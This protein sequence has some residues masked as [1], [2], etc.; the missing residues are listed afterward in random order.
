MNLAL[1]AAISLCLAGAAAA[2]SGTVWAW[3]DNTS[4]E[5]G[6]NSTTSS[7]SAVQ[8]VGPSG[9][10]HLT[11][12]RAVA[13]GGDFTVA[14]RS[15][16][17]V[18]AWGD[19]SSGELGD[20][21]AEGQSNTPVQVLGLNG[22]GF[23]TGVRAVAAGNDFTV[24][25]LSDGTIAAW[26]DNRSGQLGD[27][28]TSMDSA[29]AVQ[30]AGPGGS[31]VLS[32]LVAVAAGS[33]HT[34][35]LR[36]DGTVWAWGD[37]EYG[38]LGN[39]TTTGYG[40]N[41]CPVQVLGLNGSGYLT[42]VVAVA[43][44]DEFTVA[45]KSDGTVWAWGYNKFG[46]V[47]DG[48]TTNR[49]TPV[50]VVG[51]RGTGHLT[52]VV[53]VAAGEEPA[54]AVKSDGTVWCWGSGGEGEL[55]D[56]GA[57]PWTFTP[58]QVLGFGGSGYLTGVVA[59][60][61]GW[62]HLVALKSDGT[63]AAW[64]Y[65]SSGELGDNGPEGQSNVPVPVAGLGGAGLLTGIAAV[66]AGDEFTVALAS[67]MLLV[68][69]S[70][71]S[72]W[73]YQ[74]TPQSTRDRHYLTLTTSVT[75][76]TWGGNTSYT[77]T[78]SLSGSGLVRPSATFVNSSGGGAV[79]PTTSFAFA[80][81]T[82]GTLYLVGGRVQGGGV[83]G[84][85]ANLAVTGNCTVTVSVAGNSS[86]ASHPATA[87]VIINVSVLGDI[88]DSG[89]VDGA[90]LAT[91][92]SILNKVLNNTGISPQTNADGDLSGDSE[93]TAADRVILYRIINGLMVP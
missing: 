89:R 90:D 16:S 20:N 56:N 81:G 66:A 88:D 45:L 18:W 57:E 50:Q 12:V 25:L 21:Q 64:G 7:G 14:L 73:V 43:A 10:G 9:S 34:V 60:A 71:P 76:D 51:P 5:L 24:A 68:T 75:A 8:V 41:P 30:V 74:N 87:S 2:Q 48:T 39:N 84:S 19:N 52:G 67:P 13:A 28:A 77:A 92:L 44:G 91:D 15:T 46:Q 79:T 36:S 32:G 31:G 55:G 17:T 49:S 72:D 82:T 37:N 83:V 6:N 27:G 22:S 85:A 58:V 3:G 61:A 1:A 23:L 47:G 40:A 11:G 59:I 80:A 62:F 69:T 35:A 65:N 33:A 26:G 53:A 86:G 38:E 4:G 78:V 29:V 93:V 63:V 42:G 54:A 70:T